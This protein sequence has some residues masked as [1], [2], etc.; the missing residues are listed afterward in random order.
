MLGPAASVVPV[1]LDPSRALHLDYALA[2]VGPG[3]GIVH[4]AAFPNGLPAPLSDYRLVDVDRTT[5]AELG[6][7]GLCLDPATLVLQSRHRALGR[8]LQAFGI[9][10]IGL[11][12]DQHVALGGGFRCATAAWRRA[13]A[14]SPPA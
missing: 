9:D 8:R 4:R 1:S 6:I 7:N 5:F 10:V 14:F 13:P 2:L 11:E 3:L 12:F